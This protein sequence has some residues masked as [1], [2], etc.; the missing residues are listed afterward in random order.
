MKLDEIGARLTAGR[1]S[2]QELSPFSRTVIVGA[3]KSAVAR[4]FGVSRAIVQVPRTRRLE[5]LIRREKRYIIQLTKRKPRLL[6]QMLTN[7]LDTR[8]SR[9]TIRRKRILLTKAV[10]MARYQFACLWLENTEVLIRS[11]QKALEEGLLLVYNGTRHFQQD[12]AKVYTSTS[13]IEWLLN[14]C[15]WWSIDQAQVDKLIDSI[16]CRLAI[17]K[18][19]RG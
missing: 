16:P 11:Y 19:A 5:V 17:V 12:N 8:I 6:T 9:S 7:T 2:G 14:Y 10:A 18:K 3:S 13:S 15:C 1:Q 4:M